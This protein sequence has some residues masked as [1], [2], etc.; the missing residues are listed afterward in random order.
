MDYASNSERLAKIK[1]DAAL[2]EK[3]EEVTNCQLIFS[4]G[5]VNIKSNSGNP[6][7]E[8]ICKNI[9]SAFSF[10]FDI[11][12]AFLLKGSNYYFKY[13]NLEDFSFTEKRIKQIKARI[14]GVHGKT[15]R[16]IE[17][18]S[19]ARITIHNS[20]VSFIGSSESIE[21]SELAVKALMRG[22]THKH[23]YAKM[24]AVHRGNRQA[25]RPLV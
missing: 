16:Y 19:S 4:K 7:E 3:I 11:E 12:D 8:Y 21:E 13:I 15:K 6:V 24:E 18:V 2:K 1:K 20:I 17:S 10:G 9:L 22:E 14:I 25:S 23:A 5:E